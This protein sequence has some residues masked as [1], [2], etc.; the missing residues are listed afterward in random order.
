MNDTFTLL[1]KLHIRFRTPKDQGLSHSIR[2]VRDGIASMVVQVWVRQSPPRQR[3]F[4]Q[5]QAYYVTLSQADL[6]RD[7]K[8]LVRVVIERVEVQ[9]PKRRP[10]NEG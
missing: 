1:A 3:T 4:V 10:A 5:H 9:L 7:I 8:D 2:I 6:D